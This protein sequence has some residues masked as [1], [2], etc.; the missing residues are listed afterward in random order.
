MTPLHI[1]QSDPQSHFNS[2]PH[3]EDDDSCVNELELKNHFNS[4]PHKED[5]GRCR[6]G[7]EEWNYFNSHPHKEDDHLEEEEAQ[8]QE[9][10]THILTRR[11]TQDYRAVTYELIFQLTSSQG[12]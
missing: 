8:P 12:G 11:M 6:G 2:H 3:K 9:I 1:P 4:H 5:D 7:E 10:S